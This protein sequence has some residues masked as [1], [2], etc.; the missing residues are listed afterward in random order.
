MR[1]VEALGGAATPIAWG[2]LYTALQ[3][4]VVDGAENNPQFLSVTAVR[5]VEVLHL[6]EHTSVPDILL[7]SQHIWEG[8]NPQQQVWLQQAA[9]ESA[10]L[11]RELWQQAT[12][13]ALAAVEA[14]GWKSSFP[15]RRPLRLP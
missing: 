5:G 14:A 4:G 12:A 3:Q 7:V 6:D 2:E 13:E 10:Q 9:D 8:L 11:Q 15:T 1:M